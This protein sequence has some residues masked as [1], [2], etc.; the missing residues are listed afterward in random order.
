MSQELAQV[1]EQKFYPRAES[2]D[3][4]PE[5]VGMSGDTVWE[6]PTNLDVVLPLHV[7][8]TETWMAKRKPT[9]IEQ[10]GVDRKVIPAHSIVTIS[11]VFDRAIQ[12]THC[13]EPECIGDRRGCRSTKHNKTIVGGYGPQL[14][15]RGMKVKPNV[16]SALNAHQAELDRV[17]SSLKETEMA[18][19]KLDNERKAAQ[20][21]LDKLKQEIEA[22][23]VT[24]A[25][26][27]TPAQGV[28]PLPK[29]KG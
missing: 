13:N 26:A 16:H 5:I 25:E 20:L 2:L 4:D 19:F 24:R 7:G 6:N 15:N 9:Y 21:E 1:S 11:S 23:K 27:A 17:M 8:S 12:D 18:A 28:V 3:A 14:I 29:N 10:F 22:A